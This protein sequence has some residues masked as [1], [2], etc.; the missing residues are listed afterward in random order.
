MKIKLPNPF[1]RDKKYRYVF[2][3]KKIEELLE[4]FGARRCAS[5]PDLEEGKRK[6]RFEVD[7]RR[8]RSIPLS[9]QLREGVEVDR[10]PLKWVDPP[11]N[12]CYNVSY[13]QLSRKMTSL[14]GKGAHKMTQTELELEVRPG[15]FTGV[16]SDHEEVR[17]D[18]D[19]SRFRG[20]KFF[21]SKDK[22]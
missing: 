12:N 21:A 18:R 19:Q 17:S 7:D 13:K 20:R 4:L 11:I 15:Q 8:I 16:Y 6:Q 5:V 2:L 22:S 14:N 10:P 3:N 9:P 1:R